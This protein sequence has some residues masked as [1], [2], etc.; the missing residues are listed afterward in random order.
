MTTTKPAVEFCALVGKEG[1][2]TRTSGDEDGMTAQ[3][4]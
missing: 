4:Y 3:T 2:W 1:E